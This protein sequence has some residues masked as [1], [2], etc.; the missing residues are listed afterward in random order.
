MARA[1]RLEYENAWHHV[2]NRAAGKKFV[3]S[4]ENNKY[5]FFELIAEACKKHEIEIHAYCLMDNHYH[6]LIRTPK[7][8]LSKA[9]HYIQF[10]FSK[11]YNEIIQSDGPIFRSRY[12]SILIKNDVYLT[13]VCRY[14]HLNPVEAKLTS[15]IEYKW[16]SYRNYLDLF[17]KPYWLNTELLTE[18][19]SNSFDKLS[20]IEFHKQNN[21][22]E[23]NSFY[24]KNN[25]KKFVEL[26]Y[27]S[28]STD[29]KALFD[30]LS[31]AIK[32][33]KSKLS[34]FIFCYLAR[35]IYNHKVTEI[36]NYLSEDSNNISAVLS[37]NK[38]KVNSDLFL[39]LQ[40]LKEK[41]Q[42]LIEVAYKYLR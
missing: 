36:S 6:L 26:E 11:I 38:S 33:K 21:S 12:K 3:F 16:S 32:N 1:R 9:I 23:I 2:M 20:F 4:D 31:N 40:N 5:I 13:Q 34:R 42:D 19:I 25:S 28:I 27:Q 41:P 14:I 35:N 22:S 8:N 29:P 30:T 10:R 37:R 18:M 24:E 17:K 7:A 39:K 15:G